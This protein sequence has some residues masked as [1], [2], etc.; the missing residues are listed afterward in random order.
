MRFYTLFLAA[1]VF[2]LAFMINACRPP[3]LE[4]TVIDYKAGRY[5]NAYEEALKSAEKY[6]DNEEAWFYLGQIQGRKGLIKEM[7]SSFDKSMA[8]K[9]TFANDIDLSKRNYFGLDW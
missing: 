6:P 8:L 1:V 4:Q 2:S 7:M 9:P 5:E 3:E